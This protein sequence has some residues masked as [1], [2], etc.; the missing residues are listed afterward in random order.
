MIKI[1]GVWILAE[2]SGRSFGLNITT[3]FL[4]P[5]STPSIILCKFYVKPLTLPNCFV[6]TLLQFWLI[7]TD[8]RPIRGGRPV[9]DYSYQK[10]AKYPD[11]LATGP[12][13]WYRSPPVHILII[14]LI[15]YLLLP[16]YLSKVIH[17]L[18]IA[19]IDAFI[20]LTGFPLP[21][22]V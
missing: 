8:W 12:W 5:I 15:W 7:M 22:F 13:H 14:E 19:N 20:K 10:L 21:F 11:G 4:I 1:V 3:Q 18:I 9:T 17:F 2:L 6:L 16:H